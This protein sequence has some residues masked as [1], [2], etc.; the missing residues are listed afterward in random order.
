MSGRDPN[1][2]ARRCGKCGQS[3]RC[4]AVRD[5]YRGIAHTGTTYHHTC[6][7]CGLRVRTVSIWKAVIDLGAI[8]LMIAICLGL[9]GMML[10]QA[11]SMTMSGG[12]MLGLQWGLAAGTLALGLLFV[13]VAVYSGS[14]VLNRRRHPLIT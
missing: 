10:V 14:A 2:G 13:G 11:V 4:D 12:R 8:G 1:M 7:G 5:H 6:A 3:M 9:G